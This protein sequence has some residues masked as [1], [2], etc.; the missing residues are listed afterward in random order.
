[1][2]KDTL[3][4]VLDRVV[5]DVVNARLPQQVLLVDAAGVTGPKNLLVCVLVER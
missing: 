4:F 5:E 1:M 3:V 2:F